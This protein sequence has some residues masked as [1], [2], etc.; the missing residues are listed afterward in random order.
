[1]RS[2]SRMR[3]SSCQVWLFGALAALLLAALLPALSAGPA[4]AATSVRSGL[5]PCGPVCRPPV[6]ADCSRDVAREFN[7]WLATVPD[8]SIIDLAPGGCYLVNETRTT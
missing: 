2:T 8:G 6:P 7:D 4:P 3:R 5:V 1:M